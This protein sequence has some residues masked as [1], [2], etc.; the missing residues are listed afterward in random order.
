MENVEI[1]NMPFGRLIIHR[2]ESHLCRD[3]IAD[4]NYRYKFSEQEYNVYLGYDFENVDKTYRAMQMQKGIYLGHNV[5]GSCKLHI[6]SNNLYLYM[7]ESQNYEKVFWSFAVK[8]ILTAVGLKEDVLH[9]KG[10]LLRN[11]DG[12]MVL[13]LGKGQSGKTT[14]GRILEIR[15]YKIVSNTHCFVKGNYVW[16]INSWI[17]VRN[18]E[19]QEYIIPKNNDYF[20]DG[21][22]KK[23]YIIDWNNRG[24]IKQYDNICDEEKYF[25]IKNF[26]A[27]ICNYDLKEEV[28]DYMSE[29][30]QLKTRIDCFLREDVLIK[31]F[32]KRSIEFVSI[33][34]KSK[35]CINKFISMMED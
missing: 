6:E 31:E 8:Y 3:V 13:L 11:P 12:K 14:L 27:A 33:D 24:W 4:G 5:G 2:K 34:S 25:Y 32:A 7:N 20:I 1:I 18:A 22:I 10:L 26:V 19:G 21:E 23:C 28:W 15:G 9:I 30:D 16:G 29:N 17:R 35:A